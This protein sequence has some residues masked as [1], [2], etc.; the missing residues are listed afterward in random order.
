MTFNTLFDM[1]NFYKQN[2]ADNEKISVSNIIRLETMY[3]HIYKLP[4]DFV[5]ASNTDV[6]NL[7]SLCI[8]DDTYT[9]VIIGKNITINADVKL[10]PPYRC[11]GLIIYASDTLVNHGT[12]SMY[13]RGCSATGQNIYLLRDEY[14]PAVGAAGAV[15]STTSSLS[16]DGHNYLN[17]NPGINGTGRQTGGGGS[18]SVRNYVARMYPG[19]G[20]AGTSYSGGAGGGA[21]ATDRASSR[22]A[23]DGSSTGGAGGHGAQGGAATGNSGGSTNGW[24]QA[25]GGGQG[26]GPGNNVWSHAVASVP[27]QD[28]GTGGLLVIYCD[29]FNNQNNINADGV[30]ARYTT[31]SRWNG[32]QGGGHNLS[33]GSSGGGSVNIFYNTLQNKGTI[34][35]T[36]GAAQWT[37][38]TWAGGK[39]GDGTVTLSILEY[40]YTLNNYIQTLDTLSYTLQD[41]KNLGMQNDTS[42]IGQDVYQG[43][44]FDHYE[45]DYSTKHAIV[46]CYYTRNIYTLTLNNGTSQKYS[47]LYEEQGDVHYNGHPIDYLHK[48]KD[49]I[50]DIPV[51]IDLPY[52]KDTTFIMPASDI[53]ISVEF[54]DQDRVNTNIYKNI[55]DSF[56]F[57]LYNLQIVLNG[58]YKRETTIFQYNHGFSVYDLL[59]LNNSGLYEKGLAIESKY[60]IIGMVSKIL[61]QNEFILVTYG[62][63]ETNLNFTSD[64]GILYL[65]D[66]QEGKFCTYEELESD[67]YT[68]IGFYTGNTIT[69]SILDSSVGDVL[70]KYHDTVYEHEQDLPHITEQDK[71]DII[72]GVLN[73]A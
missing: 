2:M 14:V 26:N 36:G 48:F 44:T 35:A 31:I 8:S 7:M 3:F 29:K 22:T 17:G 33:G 37:G 30:T 67:F 47:Y 23:G 55:F 27:T 57:D 73:N 69:L 40:E 66:T 43:F 62:P 71:Q 51:N 4:D 56:L 64:S 46:D 58:V 49:W 52:L 65:S 25:A 32:S 1:I 72:Q 38:M 11:K 39:G 59:R 70:K 24:G 9:Q 18:G 54:T 60:D 42:F 10:T 28:V 13:G 16:N 12:I 6:N 34:T 15:R 41:T 63:I 61:N 21:A 50:S 68:P 5:F 19:S 53:T 20:G 45:A